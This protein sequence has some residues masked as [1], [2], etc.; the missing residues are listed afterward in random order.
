MLNNMGRTLLWS[1]GIMMFIALNGVLYGQSKLLDIEFVQIAAGRFQ[2]GE[3]GRV[4]PVHT[5]TLDGFQMAKYETTYAQWIKVYQWAVEHGYQF[6]NAGTAGRNPMGEKDNN[7]VAHINWYDAVKWCNALSEMEGKKPVYYRDEEKSQVF[8]AGQIKLMNQWVD[9]SADGYRLP[10]EAEWEYAYRAGTTT[11]FPWGD[12][13]HE[14]VLYCWYG[15]DAYLRNRT[16]AVGKKLPNQWGLYDM[17]GNVWEWCWDWHEGYDAEP[18]VNPMGP[19]RGAQRGIRGGTCCWPQLLTS[20][21]RGSFLPDK[22]LYNHGLRI[23]KGN[24]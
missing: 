5:V 7:P 23:V 16:S 11:I 4:E 13:Y 20:A 1:L 19:S 12:A 17:G 22:T 6:D 21:Q 24:K 10:T 3:S 8:R 18:Q 15:S 14:A 2:M 9:T